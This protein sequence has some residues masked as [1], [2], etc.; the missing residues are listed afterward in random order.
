[1]SFKRKIAIPLFL[2][3]A[4]ASAFAQDVGR[5]SEL[6]DSLQA[7]YRLTILG[8]GPMGVHGDNSIRKAGGTV[9]LMKDGLFGSH[10]RKKLPANAIQDDKSAVVSG[11]KEVELA[12]GEK[13]YVTAAYV[14]SDVVTLGLLST[15]MIPGKGKASQVW[16]SVNFFFAQD[17]LAQ[18]NMGK[19]YSVI[20]QWVLP[21][22]TTTAPAPAVVSPASAP[23]PAVAP[24]SS[25]PVDLQPGMSRDDVVNALG[26]PLQDV[27]FGEHRWLTYPGISVTLE[28][29]KV[30]A[31]ERNAQALVPVRIS[32][33]PNGA[34]VFLD[35]SFVSSAPSVLR[36]HAGTYKVVVKASGYTDWERE[37]KV[38]PG[39]EV[40]LDAKLSK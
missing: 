6:E 33:D 1:M 30:T 25:K 9:L 38:L 24:V 8:G 36:L 31:V 28:H 23:V 39:A 13:F 18:G 4:W 19:V 12:Q 22:G 14:G 16:C 5:R 32:S 17:T 20:D 3:A 10:D 37:V 27:E 29:G 34:D 11:D 21:E 2:G 15:R 35:G 26:A 7:R 40:N